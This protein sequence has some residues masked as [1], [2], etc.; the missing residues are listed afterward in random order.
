MPLEIALADTLEEILKNEVALTQ[1]SNQQMFDTETDYAKMLSV[2]EGVVHD[3]SRLDEASR[4]KYKNMRSFE[5][6]RNSPDL[7]AAHL[8]PAKNFF[9]LANEAKA[10]LGA[11]DLK[12]LPIDAIDFDDSSIEL[13]EILE[14]VSEIRDLYKIRK[15]TVG[16][17]KNAGINADEALRLKNCFAQG[18]ELYL[19]GKNGSLM[20][21]PLNFFYAITAYSYGIIVLNNPL[22]FCKGNLPGPHGLSYLSDNVQIQFGG[23]TARGTFSDLVTSFPIHLL[24]N[25]TIEMQLDCTQSVISFYENRVRTSLGCL[26]SMVPELSE[27]YKLTTGEDSRCFPLQITNANDPRSLKWEFQIGNGELRP[28]LSSIDDSF[29]GFNRSDRY[30]KTIVSVSSEDIP[31]IRACIYSDMYGDFWYIENPFHPIILPEAGLHFLISNLFSNIM[32][33]MPD[34]WGNVLSNNVSSSIGLL[35]RHYFSSFQRK[36]LIVV[37][38]SASRHIPYV[39]RTS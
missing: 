31:K 5:T 1:A 33:Y 36:F 34:E 23:D 21:K 13:V 37:L 9:L 24:R 28:S 25:K 14:S 19:A 6:E 10:R 4:A 22:R 30:G 15:R 17:G 20:V 18:R 35:T 2:R 11:N 3:W 8:I 26:L 12:P 29:P 16:S 7:K 39:A 32:R 27:Y 38:R